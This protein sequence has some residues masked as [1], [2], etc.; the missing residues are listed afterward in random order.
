MEHPKPTNMYDYPVGIPTITWEDFPTDMTFEDYHTRAE[1]YGMQHTPTHGRI[2][3]TEARI[4]IGEGHMIETGT[5]WMAGAC[6]MAAGSKTA[7]RE[8]LITVDIDRG[9]KHTM[10]TTEFYDRVPLGIARAYMNAMMMGVQDWIISIRGS[11]EEVV[12][13]LDIKVRLAAIDGGHDEDNC[14][15]DIV[16]IEP[17]MISGA[18]MIFHDYNSPT[19]KEALNK[20]VIG[21]SWCDEFRAL[22]EET[23]YAVKK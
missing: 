2:L 19:V 4:G 5:Y 18:K 3:F 11:V 9:H 14:G 13:F 12:P 20:Y 16:L 15:L 7:R 10:Y 23:A 17:L 21:A 1:A 6:Y 22:S 8:K